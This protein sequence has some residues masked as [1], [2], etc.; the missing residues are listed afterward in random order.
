VL[1]RYSPTGGLD[2]TFGRSGWVMIGPAGR[3]HRNMVAPAIQPSRKIVVAGDATLGNG[4]SGGF[5]RYKNAGKVDESFGEHGRVFSRFRYYAGIRALVYQRG[6]LLAAGD[7]WPV[8]PGSHHFAV[9]RYVA[10][11]GKLDTRFGKGGKVTT[12]FPD[13]GDDPRARS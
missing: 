3:Q 13:S 9:A 7:D 10:T 1:A 6:T 5:A 2:R 11:S 4:F 12:T 8:R